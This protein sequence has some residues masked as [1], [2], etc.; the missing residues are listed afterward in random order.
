[1]LLVAAFNLL[2]TPPYC[3][4]IKY[5]WTSSLASPICLAF[6][7]FKVSEFWYEEG[8]YP[9]LGLQIPMQYPVGTRVVCVDPQ[10][11]N[12]RKGTIKDY[13]THPDKQETPRPVQILHAT[14]YSSF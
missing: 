7:L 6:L 9:E 3:W 11:H 10:T 8:P 2:M 12:Q 13:L 4:T 1:L 5:L 14:C